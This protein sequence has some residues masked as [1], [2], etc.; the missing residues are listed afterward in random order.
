[1]RPYIVV[2]VEPVIQ[3]LLGFF[4]QGVKLAAEGLP[5]KLVE[6]G[7]FK[8]LHKSA[9]ARPGD[10]SSPVLDIIELQE[11]PKMKEVSVTTATY[12]SSPAQDMN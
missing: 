9:G 1:M 2:V 8:P 3:V 11:N 12:G 5:E 4:H 7:C 10:V 6:D